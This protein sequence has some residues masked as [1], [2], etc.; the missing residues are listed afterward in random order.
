MG[1]VHTE[2]H[3]RSPA[4]QHPT[5]CALLRCLWL[6]NAQLL[7]VAERRLGAV[8]SPAASEA[9][10][11]QRDPMWS[12]VA[13]FA[14]QALLVVLSL[15]SLVTLSDLEN[16]F[17]NPIDCAARLNLLV[18]P[19]L[20]LLAAQTAWFLLH[21]RWYLTLLYGTHEH[22]ARTFV[23]AALTPRH[24][25]AAV[26][27]YHARCYARGEALVDATEV[28]RTLAAEKRARLARLGVHVALFVLV[29]YGLIGHALMHAASALTG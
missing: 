1:G 2:Q 25:A 17:L 15:F 9:L 10:A 24:L 6:R 14:L 19:E 18:K 20:A 28:I 23:T 4:R 3:A 26:L 12:W 7:H 22:R 21:G 16:D 5:S 13:P 8:A 11:A 29:I 27:A